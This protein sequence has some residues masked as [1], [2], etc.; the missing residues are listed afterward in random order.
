M[1]NL[2]N[3]LLLFCMVFFMIS[4]KENDAVKTKEIK[5]V[6]STDTFLTLPG[7]SWLSKPENSKTAQ[8]L[9]SFNLYYSNSLKEKNYEHAAGY[10]I[11]FGS[12]NKKN[13]EIDTTYFKE[14][15]R[16]YEAYNI[17]ISDEAK[18]HLCHY[19]GA[20][21][22]K[23]NNIAQSMLWHKRCVS[24]PAFSTGHQQIEGFSHF[25]IG[26]NFL[27]KREL[28]SAEVH[29]VKA[30]NIFEAVGDVKNQGTVYMLLFDLFVQNNA[31][32]EAEKTLKKAIFIAK[33]QQNNYLIFAGIS[34][35]IHFYIEQG[36]TLNAVR[37][38]DSLQLFS[39]SYTDMSAYFQCNLEQYLSFKYVS[40][41]NKDSAVFHLNKANEI[42]ERLE[43][44]DLKARVIFQEILFAFHLKEPLRN[45]KEVEV[46]YHELQ[47]DKEP[48]KQLMFQIST[49]LFDYYQS[50]GN[51]Q[52][53]N[54][55]ANFLVEDANRQKEERVS[56]RLFELERKFEANKKEKQILLQENILAKKNK[57][58]SILSIGSLM[59]VLLFSLLFTWLKNKNILKQQLLTESFASQLLSKT[60]EERKRIASDLHDSV[61]NELV[62]LRQILHGE[63]IQLKHKIDNIL[64]EVR[65]ISRNISPT[66]FENIGFQSSLEQLI[67][68]IQ[69]QHNFFISSEIEYHG[70]LGSEKE[71][72]LFRII[73]ESITNMIKHANAVAG[74]VTIVEHNGLV[75]IE[76]KDNGKGFDVNA[77]LEKGKCFGL[78][79]ITERTKLI[80]GKT[81]FISNAAGTIINI[82]IPT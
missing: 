11:A 42:A 61:S 16:F 36:D 18:S 47:E 34:S 44:P 3:Y 41:N 49:T 37:Q 19:I 39:K 64:E 57:T 54:K 22:Y 48:N 82:T 62:G 52:L 13:S 32:E 30:L 8:Y 33:E 43:S 31:F 79:N 66:L 7:Y 29:L 24:F 38:I 2:K 25:S 12:A 63:N 5:L 21:F 51:F 28:D 10:L 67:E 73:Q 40:E 26:Q 80:N 78:L 53:A 76:I 20:L 6:D 58:I 75:N 59:L 72:Q 14:V 15:I 23:E 69:N 46:F 65:N 68:R 4:C 77:V 60:E 74:K 81:N 9:D 50:I 27:R 55:Y 17:W 70:G 1:S 56:G 35:Y 71:L 45:P